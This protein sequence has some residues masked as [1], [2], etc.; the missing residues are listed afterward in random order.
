MEKS[1]TLTPHR[2]AMKKWPHSWTITTNDKTKTN[3]NEIVCEIIDLLK[4]DNGL[5]SIQLIENNGTFYFLEYE[6]FPGV[7]ECF[8]QMGIAE[9][10]YDLN[11]FI[12]TTKISAIIVPN[13]Y[14]RF[15]DKTSRHGYILL[16]DTLNQIS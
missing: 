5:Y 8:I 6:P 7:P 12:P 10:A 13:Y 9:S 3:V 1:V 14:Q 15:D 2:R 11:H 16:N 4:F